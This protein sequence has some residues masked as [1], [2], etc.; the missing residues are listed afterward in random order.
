MTDVQYA[1]ALLSSCITAHSPARPSTCTED[2]DTGAGAQEPDQLH[3]A[4]QVSGS[5]VRAMLAGDRQAAAAVAEELDAMRGQC[6]DVDE[7]DAAAFLQVLQ[8]SSRESTAALMLRQVRIA[9]CHQWNT[10]CL[11]RSS[12]PPPMVSW[13]MVKQFC[14]QHTSLLQGMLDHRISRDAEHLHGPYAKAFNRICNQVPSQST[15]IA[16]RK[17]APLVLVMHL[18]C[19]MV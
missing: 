3:A 9:G 18:I 1:R 11:R 14:E 19:W 17:A 8:V 15:P 13:G 7:R 5:V 2:P 12:W 10:P 4:L 6:L 16:H